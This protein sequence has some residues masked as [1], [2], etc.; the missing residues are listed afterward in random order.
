MILFLLLPM[1]ASAA[2]LPTRTFHIGKKEYVVVERIK[3]VWVNQECAK[4]CKAL[5]AAKK[6]YPSPV[7]SGA[8]AGSLNPGTVICKTFNNGKVFIAVDAERNQM[9]FCKFDDGSFVN[10]GAFQW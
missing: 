4:S 7:S 5:E 9:S 6:K 10:S 8:S 1:L 3:D 2:N